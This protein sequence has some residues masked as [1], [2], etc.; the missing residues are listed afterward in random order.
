MN[1][2]VEVLMPLLIK[3]Y[4]LIQAAYSSA[5]SATTIFFA[6]NGILI[7]I[8]I[9]KHVGILLIVGGLIMIYLFY[10]L[11]KGGKAL[12]A[13]YK[14]A[15][16]LEKDL[17]IEEK[18]ITSSFLASF[19]NKSYLKEVLKDNGTRNIRSIYD[20]RNSNSSKAIVFFGIIQILIGLIL[21]LFFHWF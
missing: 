16:N 12:S 2:N 4:D 1:Q 3:T 10:I 18:G 21:S 19:R 9:D 7:T 20:P 6:A 13:L 5:T 8:A 14:V 15:I 11:F 17:S